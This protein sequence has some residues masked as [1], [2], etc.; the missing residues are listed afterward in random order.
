M[1]FHLSTILS[2]LALI[3]HLL[4]YQNSYHTG[5]L[6]AIAMFTNIRVPFDTLQEEWCKP[7]EKELNFAGR[8]KKP[9]MSL[10]RCSEHHDSDEGRK[11]RVI[12]IISYMK[13]F[14]VKIKLMH[15]NHRYGQCPICL[16]DMFSAARVTGCS[17][18]FHAHCLRKSL[19]I[20]GDTCPMCR[21][22]IMD[23]LMEKQENE[24]IQYSEF[25][26]WHQQM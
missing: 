25:S 19:E 6:A 23:S 18:I 5:I 11:S 7:L 21:N 9:A 24:D 16:E 22:P 3:F 1:M 20:I 26:Y 12:M 14:L 13:R 17:H 15:S 2:S 4:I 8:M 10:R